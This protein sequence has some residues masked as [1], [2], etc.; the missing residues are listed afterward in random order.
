MDEAHSFDDSIAR[1]N[2]MEG[3]VRNGSGDLN[4]WPEDIRVRM[5]PADKWQV[6][7]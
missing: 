7:W 4:E 3:I 6:N 1:R 2:G 5:M